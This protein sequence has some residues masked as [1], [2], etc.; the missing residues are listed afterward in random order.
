MKYSKSYN[1]S[2]IPFDVI[3]PHFLVSLFCGL[4]LFLCVIGTTIEITLESFENCTDNPAHVPASH[5]A[6]EPIENYNAELGNIEIPKQENERTPL[7]EK[8][9]QQN[10]K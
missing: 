10:G 3:N 8:I 7:L 6:I 9:K 1:Y 2:L 4:I 5:C